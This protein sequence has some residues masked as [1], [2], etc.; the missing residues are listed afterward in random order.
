MGKITLRITGGSGISTITTYHDK[1]V[2]Y[3]IGTR[4]IHILH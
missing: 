2:I 1:F 3:H 4:L